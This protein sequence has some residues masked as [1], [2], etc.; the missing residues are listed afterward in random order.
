[1]AALKAWQS[2]SNKLWAISLPYVCQVGYHPTGA[3]DAARC[4]AYPGVG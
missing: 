4:W 3:P 2:W 1:M